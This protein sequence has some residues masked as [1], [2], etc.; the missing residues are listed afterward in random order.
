[1]DKEDL[2]K[3]NSYLNENLGTE[4]DGFLSTEWTISK[5]MSAD[6]IVVPE[7]YNYGIHFPIKIKNGTSIRILETEISQPLGYSN[8]LLFEVIDPSIQFKSKFRVDLK[9]LVK[10]IRGKQ[11]K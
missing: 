7:N 5:S 10:C 1:M 2:K 6:A 9:H 4:I 11:K 8:D 3:L